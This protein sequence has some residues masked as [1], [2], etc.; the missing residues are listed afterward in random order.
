MAR[1][2]RGLL[3]G[4]LVAVCAAFVALPAWSQ[5]KGPPDI[6]F[7]LK[8]DQLTVDENREIV[9]AAGNVEISRGGQVLLADKV[10]YNQKTER[11]TASGN[12]TLLHPT[13][14][15]TFAEQAEFS[16]DF[17]DG[18]ARGIRMLLTDDSRLAGVSGRRSEG[19]ITEIKKGVFSPCKL[20]KG[21]APPAA[22][23]GARLHPRYRCV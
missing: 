8:A 18:V 11:L 3:I 7:L 4:L 23:P 21:A 14:E 5:A 2:L 1:L 22:S 13:G 17:K 9:V 15:V 19:L 20:C 16:D 12:V 10:I 6:P